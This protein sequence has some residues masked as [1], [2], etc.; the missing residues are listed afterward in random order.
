MLN[1]S[2]RSVKIQLTLLR[3]NK[4][5]KPRCIARQVCFENGEFFC[6]VSLCYVTFLIHVWPTLWEKGPWS[7]KVNKRFFFSLFLIS[8]CSKYCAWHSS[9]E[10]SA[11]LT[12]FCD[13]SNHSLIHFILVCT[14]LPF[15][16]KERI[17]CLHS[18]FAFSN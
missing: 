12:T 1:V 5:L 16:R 14:F 13:L 17:F 11:L 3:L 9:M 18:M 4:S 15:L 2:A 6:L 7:W 10:F 8:R